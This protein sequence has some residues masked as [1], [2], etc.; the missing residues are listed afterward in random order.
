MDFNKTFRE[1]ANKKAMSMWGLI[2][3][4]LTIAYTIEVVKGHRTVPYFIVFESLCWVPLIIGVITVSIQ[5]WESKLLK[6]IIAAGYGVFYAFAVITSDTNLTF[7]YIFPIA[8]VLLLYKDRVMFGIMMALNTLLIVVSFILSKAGKTA[9]ELTMAEF[10]IQL[11][12]VIICYTGFII[13]LSHLIKTEATL[14]GSVQDNLSK[15]THTVEQVKTAS[16]AVVDGVSIVR[17]LSDENMDAA[18]E[19]VDS[20][21]QLTKKNDIMQSR[22]KSSIEMLREIDDQ[23]STVAALAEE[24]I[25]TAE[26]SKNNAI[27]SAKELEEVVEATEEM[28]AI[29]SEVENI[30]LEFKEE[31]ERAKVETGTITA[32]TNQTNLLSLNASIEAARAGDAGKGFAVVA[33][34]IRNLSEGTKDSSNRILSAID[35]LQETSDKMTASIEKTIAIIN[36]NHALIEQVNKSVSQITKDSINIGDNVHMVGAA[37]QEVEAANRNLVDN[38]NEVAEVMD[39]TNESINA[40]GKTTQAM[41][42]KYEEMSSN[43]SHIEKV[44]DKLVEELG[45][46]GYMGLKD[47]KPGMSVTLTSMSEN[48]KKYLFTA[49]S[50]LSDTDM[51]II[52]AQGNFSPANNEKYQMLV[53]VKNELFSWEQVSINKFNDKVIVFVTGNPTVIN[54]RKSKRIEI[55]NDCMVSIPSTQDTIKCKMLNISSTGFAFTT[56]NPKV[57]QSK[58]GMIRLEVM[59]YEPLKGQIISGQIVRAS[60]DNGIFTIGCRT[61]NEHKEIYQE[62]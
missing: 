43:V 9:A 54:R 37:M 42:S 59:D 51:V 20:M 3:G 1:G 46:S 62:S 38:M 25:A 22:A 31:F 41:M 57:V 36:R 24:M 30:L 34:E 5:K 60:N 11:A 35:R 2:C 45:E 14:V 56:T 55:S 47:I 10:E 16:S 32:I 58:G 40:A 48:G 23:I 18:N 7:V 27:E 29:S 52:P 28:A 33:D 53:V 13:A 8:C 17:D 12:A 26:C 19:V 39:E 21:E 61:S 50:I 44:V 49:E 15:V 6:I 4:I